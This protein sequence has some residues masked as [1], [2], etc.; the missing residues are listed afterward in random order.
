MK[1]TLNFFMKTTLNFFMKTTLNFF[2]KTTLNFFMKTTNFDNRLIRA[3][4]ERAAR[5]GETLTRLIERALRDYLST[6]EQYCASLSRRTTDQARPAGRRGESGR[7]GHALRAD[8][9]PRFIAVDTNVL[10]HAH[11]EESPKHAAAHARVVALAEAPSRWEFRYSA[12][13]NLF[14]S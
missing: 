11:R 1:T 2:M 8:G 14:A 9:R 5:E 10:V 6:P 12:S 3:A 13:G 4:K 7:P